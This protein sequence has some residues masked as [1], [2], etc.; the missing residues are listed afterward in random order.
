V[1]KRVVSLFVLAA[2]SLLAIQLVLS[3]AMADPTAPQQDRETQAI[4]DLL[5]RQEERWNAGDIDGFLKYYWKSADLTFSSGGTMRRGWKATKDRY[6][7]RYPTPERMG[8]TTFSEM[9][10]RLLGKSAAMVLGR[11]NLHREPDPIGGNFTLVLEKIDGKW[12]IIHDHTS[13]LDE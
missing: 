4:K 6:N 12:L 9:E 5:T 8:R 13:Q 2:V 7:K 3:S 11:W 1:L 10:V